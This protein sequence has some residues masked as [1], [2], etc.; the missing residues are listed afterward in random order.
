VTFQKL[1]AAFYYADAANG[2]GAKNGVTK[3]AAFK[4]LEKALAAPFSGNTREIRAIGIYAIGKADGTDTGLHAF[5]G[6]LT[7]AA[8]KPAAAA[9]I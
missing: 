5:D 6:D 1:G 7:T 3:T 4:T 8:A 9:F 2:D